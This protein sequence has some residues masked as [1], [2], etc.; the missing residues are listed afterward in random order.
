MVA[1]TSRDIKAGGQKWYLRSLEFA[2]IINPL[3][4]R[5]ADYTYNYRGGVLVENNVVSRQVYCTGNIISV[6]QCVSHCF[7]KGCIGLF[8]APIICCHK[9]EAPS[10]GEQQA[11]LPIATW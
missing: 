11:K 8:F 3:S 2:S 9:C 6:E 7:H 1:L 10:R 4:C 5:F